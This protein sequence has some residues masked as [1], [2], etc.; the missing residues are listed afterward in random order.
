[1]TKQQ[2]KRILE[3]IDTYNSLIGVDKSDIEQLKK[4]IRIIKTINKSKTIEEKVIDEIKYWATILEYKI[5][6]ETNL[7]RNQILVAKRDVIVF[8]V[9]DEFNDYSPLEYIFADVFEKDRTTML[10]AMQRCKNRME[11]N[12]PLFMSQFN[13]T[14]KEA[15]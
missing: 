6:R 14:I 8:K 4:Q 3:I 5:D 15:A 2:K 12:D 7:D 13:R 10:A 9:I 1:M 11:M